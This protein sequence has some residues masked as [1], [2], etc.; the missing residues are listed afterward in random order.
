MIVC[1]VDS[2]RSYNEHYGNR[3]GDQCL[4]RIGQIVAENTKRAGDIA[5][6]YS[7]V[8]FSI[9]LP[10][11]R[12]DAALEIAETDCQRIFDQTILHRE[13]LAEKLVTASFG[14]ATL[15][16]KESDAQQ[17]LVEIA[18]FGLNRAIRSG[19]NCVFTSGGGVARDEK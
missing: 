18:D 6:R 9:S 8:Q 14:V 4:A 15:V 2:F 11:V 12:A 19:G 1:E 5:A 13:A 3:A 7:N 16:P 17:V 10:D